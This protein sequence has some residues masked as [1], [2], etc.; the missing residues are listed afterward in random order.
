MKRNLL[1]I[2]LLIAF[3]IEAALTMLCFFKPVIAMNLFGM[4]Y[5]NETSF[6]AYIIAWFCLLV[7]VL[8]IYAFVGLKNDNNGY[9]S[10]KK[11]LLCKV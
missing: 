11:F 1:Y 4:V 9:I 6:L 10:A 3:L 8:I 5:S 7:S 2:T